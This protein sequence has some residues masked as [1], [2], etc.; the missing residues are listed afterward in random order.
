MSFQLFTAEIVPQGFQ[1]TAVDRS[2]YALQGSGYGSLAFRSE[3]D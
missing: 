1:R 2:V 3:A